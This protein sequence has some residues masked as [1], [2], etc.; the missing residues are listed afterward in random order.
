MKK[1][2]TIMDSHEVYCDK[3]K[4]AVK[5]YDD[6]YLTMYVYRY[7]NTIRHADYVSIYEEEIFNRSLKK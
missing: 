4:Q 3:L 1:E 6:E 5:T 7:K 2:K